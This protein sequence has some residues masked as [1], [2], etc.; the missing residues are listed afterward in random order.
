MIIACDLFTS[1]IKFQ[2]IDNLIL[3]KIRKKIKKIKIVKIKPEQKVYKNLKNIEVYWGNR[4][5]SKLIQEMPNLKWIHFAST[6]ISRDIFS[7]IKQKK[8]LVTNTQDTFSNAVSSTVLGF[9]FS[10]ARGIHYCNF[11]R[12]KK[13]LDRQ[14][15][16]KI[17]KNVQDVYYQNI[18]IV[19]FGE[20]GNKIGKVCNT[21]GMNIFTIKKKTSRV[22]KF[23]K[24]IYQLKNLN[25]AVRGK[26][27]VINL[28]PLTKYTNEIFN[29]KIFNSMKK[30]SFFINVGRGGTVNENDLYRSLKQKK[31]LGAGLDVMIK[32]PIK[33]N[34]KFFKLNNV[35]LTPHIAGVTNNFW[36][37]QISLFSENLIRYK[38]KLGLKFEK[39]YSNLKEGY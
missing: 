12:N 25:K 8:I 27:F 18:L 35:L 10:L 21:L 15:F 34:S 24:K 7:Q 3:T 6:G 29:K 9:I 13:K 1:S 4:I 30:N 14:S 26:D 38:K 22:P 36:D 16:D 17:T 32:E 31:F 19:G 20:I 39:K 33:K 23:V 11:L 37:K 5:N 2:R 28:L